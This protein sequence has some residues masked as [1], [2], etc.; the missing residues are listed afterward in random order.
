M[1]SF[2]PPP[3]RRNSIILVCLTIF[4]GI[5]SFIII[6]SCTKEELKNQEL[7]NNVGLNQE[8][9]NQL[10]RTNP[11]IKISLESF[12]SNQYIRF[13]SIQDAQN[14]I[15]SIKKIAK[16]KIDTSV[17]S[18]PVMKNTNTILRSIYS[19]FSP[20]QFYM[21]PP[22]GSGCGGNGTYTGNVGDAGML[23]SFSITFSYASGNV[24]SANL[25]VSGLQIGWSWGNTSSYYS[26]VYG[27][28]QGDATFSYL[29]IN[30]TQTV[31]IN[32]HFH[33]ATCMLYYNQGYGGCGVAV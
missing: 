25:S 31:H 28:S 9:I 7:I 20:D 14:R 1:N 2:T 27:C 19:N 8:Q 32:W 4:T 6:N 29:G 22:P 17:H 21:L 11:G 30:Y 5:F 24:S 33:P 13:S 23:S 18:T 16:E 26:G 3:P 15:D 12:N 10:E